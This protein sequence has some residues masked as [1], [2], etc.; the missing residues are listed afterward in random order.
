MRDGPP[1]PSLHL[2][3]NYFV[4]WTL[5]SGKRKIWYDNNT[6]AVDSYI[7]YTGNEIDILFI[8]QALL[9]D[10]LAISLGVN[11]AK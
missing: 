4:P 10:T 5:F 6:F 1:T 9:V 8:S 11:K 7:Q 3:Y 2:I